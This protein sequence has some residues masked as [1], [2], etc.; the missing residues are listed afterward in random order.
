MPI[1]LACVLGLLPLVA[2]SGSL[3][4]LARA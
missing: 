4:H 2:I 3:V 1:T